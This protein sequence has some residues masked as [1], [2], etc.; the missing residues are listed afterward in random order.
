MITSELKHRAKF[1]FADI[2][3]F[4]ERGRPWWWYD[5]YHD[6]EMQEYRDENE[7]EYYFHNDLVDEYDHR[8][9]N[10]NR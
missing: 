10:R 1:F 5:Q 4:F 3:S 7:D 8:I 9:I 6:K 2:G